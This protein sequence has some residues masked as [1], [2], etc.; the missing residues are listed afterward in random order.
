MDMLFN[1]MS[2]HPKQSE[3]QRF[4]LQFLSNHSP[5]RK[6]LQI[7]QLLIRSRVICQVSALLNCR[8]GTSSPHV[9]KGHKPFQECPSELSSS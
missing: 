6:D 7:L 5:K 3:I 8:A 2:L 9:G 1:E 4:C